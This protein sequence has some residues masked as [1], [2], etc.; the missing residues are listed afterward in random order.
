MGTEREA[1]TLAAH[2]AV[3]VDVDGRIAVITIDNPP[4]N[5]LSRPVRTRLIAALEWAEGS[6]E[7]DGVVITGAQAR[8]SAG[9]NLAEFDSGVG[10]AEPTLHGTILDFLDAMT[11]PVVAA[12]A[13]VALGG[14]LELALGC[15]YRV[16]A[17]DARLGLP[18]STFGFLPGAGGTQRLPR[19]VGVPKALNMMLSGAAFLAADLAESALITR[20]VD[21]DPV[22][23][24]VDMA[25]NGLPPTRLSSIVLDDEYLEPFLDFA[26]RTVAADRNAPAGATAIIDAIRAGAGPS[27]DAFRKGLT[28]ENQLFRALADAP[29]ARAAR[30]S[31]FA[32]RNAGKLAPATMAGAREVSAGAVIGAGTMGR[33]IA[34]AL[35]RAGI[36]VTLIEIDEKARDAASDYLR[37][38]QAKVGARAGAPISLAPEIGAAAVA[39][40]IVEAAFEDLDVKCGIF[41]ELDAVAAEGAVLATNTSSLDV[42]EIAAVTSR[43]EAVL[44][45]HFFSPA[46]VMPLIEVVEGERTAPWALATAVVL[47]RRLRKA[48]VIAQVGDGFIG[49]RMIDQYTRQAMQLVLSGAALPH[50]VDGA[51]EAWGFRMGP[52]RVQDL[53]G[54]DVPAMARAAR[55]DLGSDWQLADELVA[56]GWL[57][58]KTGR[59]WYRYDG[60]HAVPDEAVLEVIAE[61]AG[62]GPSAEP[63]AIVE[64]CV[65]ALINEG[66][67]L[68]EDGIAARAS[69]I[70]VVM[71]RGYGFPA[72]RGGP[73][74][75]ADEIGL[76]NVV[77]A[78][79]AL[80][81][82]DG[83]PDG[84]WV[85]RPLLRRHAEAHQRISD[86]KGSDE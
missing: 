36:P 17:R 14:G 64:R 37:V 68:L 52:F 54:G 35:S 70:D 26:R 20:L 56:R 12:I 28:T 25:R 2:D 29:E 8:F 6:T 65:Y 53:V 27:G 48:P 63:R 3:R 75:T 66:A 45:M 61:R 85:P 41:R 34:L 86:W 50:E 78:M 67:H 57:G 51:L 21:G 38:Q 71:T 9:A 42:N 79:D 16:V 19:A 83:V 4:A 15:H 81:E 59:G 77:R 10:L 43:P 44:G 33:G 60:H 55:G 1:T 84:F 39:D 69:D 31:F 40:L 73:M 58:R 80:A 46:Q 72:R 82:R 23:A 76:G 24:A 11:K 13:G 30:Y 74:F 49:N 32:E 47:S 5:T 7:A 22:P 18:E 62:D